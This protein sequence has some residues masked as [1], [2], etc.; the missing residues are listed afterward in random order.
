MITR[1]IKRG[2]KYYT[3]KLYIKEKKKVMEMFDRFNNHK[4]HEI[5]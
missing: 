2:N 4:F 1:D 5:E 3:G